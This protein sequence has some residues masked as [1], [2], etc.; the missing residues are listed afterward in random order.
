MEKK[1][2]KEGSVTERERRKKKEE[3]RDGFCNFEII[4]NGQENEN[5]WVLSLLL[6]MFKLIA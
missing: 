5:A 3:R 1:K 4:I 6:H 2:K